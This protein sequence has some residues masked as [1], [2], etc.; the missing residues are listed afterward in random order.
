MTIF[1]INDSIIVRLCMIRRVFS[2]ALALLFMG[3]P[4]LHAKLDQDPLLVLNMD[5][6]KKLPRRFHVVA[7]QILPDEEG[8]NDVQASGS[9]Q[10]SKEG[11]VEILETIPASMD[12]IVIF[13]LR[14]ESHGFIN[15]IAISW[16][17]ENNWVN[18]GMTKEEIEI[19][20]S[21]RLQEAIAEGLVILHQEDG[22]NPSQL[23]VQEAC[24]ECELAQSLGLQYVRLPSTDHIRPCDETVDQFVSFVNQ[25]PRSTWIHF[26]CKGGKGRTS[27]FLT[28]YDMLLNAQK[29]P[30]NS[31][32]MRQHILGGINLTSP[33]VS[34]GHWKYPYSLERV[35]FL[36]Q[37]YDYCVNNPTFEIS[38]SQWKSQH[39][40]I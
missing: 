4:M 33:T 20:E 16:W 1:Y 3:L 5:N 39:Q 6:L 38:W 25:L 2:Y 37:F 23:L 15:G 21:K 14:E 12:Q 11:L 17:R 8:L 29:V 28:M 26:H 7:P 30:L 35:E 40:K 9:S 34:E 27:T 22:S 24:T 18:V 31:I 19:D 36:Q 32:L 10:F 13:D